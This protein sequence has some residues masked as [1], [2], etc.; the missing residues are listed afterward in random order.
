MNQFFYEFRGKEKV[1][2]LIVEGIRS[3]ALRRSGVAQPRFF[4]GLPKLI[5]VLAGFLGFLSGYR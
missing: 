5:L 3:Q 1:S 2:G 4:G